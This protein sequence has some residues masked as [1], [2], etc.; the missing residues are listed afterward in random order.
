MTFKIHFSVYSRKVHI[1]RKKRR[2]CNIYF[3]Y[4]LNLYILLKHC[5]IFSETDGTNL[6][7]LYTER[8]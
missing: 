5:P 8:Q 2:F 4:Y 1:D 6:L 3:A 7:A